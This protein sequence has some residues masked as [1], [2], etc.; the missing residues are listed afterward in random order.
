[1]PEADTLRHKP[2]QI[3][4]FSQCHFACRLEGLTYV[5]PLA[6]RER[7]TNAG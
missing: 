5:F 7:T 6:D 2:S 4:A 3:D 1:M